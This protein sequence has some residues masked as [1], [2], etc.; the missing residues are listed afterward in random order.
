MSVPDRRVSY[1]PHNWP[2][3][4]VCMTVECSDIK[5]H[6]RELARIVYSKQ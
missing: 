6:R 3:S 4:Y 5:I 2:N 1:A